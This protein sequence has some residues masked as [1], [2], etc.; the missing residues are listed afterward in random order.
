M[1][2]MV[3]WWGRPEN[4][5]TAYSI[6]QYA[7]ISYSVSI[8]FP[9]LPAPSS[10]HQPT[11]HFILFFSSPEATKSQKTILA[12]AYSAH[13]HLGAS[14]SPLSADPFLPRA[15]FSFPMK[16]ELCSSPSQTLP[17]LYPFPI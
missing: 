5:G 6:P 10:N 1:L 15:F 8:L 12:A 11:L 13:R 9:P 3:S 4:I 16:K 2:G 7:R 17:V 14:S